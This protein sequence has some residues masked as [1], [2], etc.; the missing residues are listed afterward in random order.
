MRMASKADQSNDLGSATCIAKRL[1]SNSL[2]ECL[3]VVA[4][5][6]ANVLVSLIHQV[7]QSS[8][9]LQEEISTNPCILV[10]SIDGIR[11][12]ILACMVPSLSIFHCTTSILNGFLRK[13]ITS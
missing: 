13:F 8:G 9:T 12:E 4:K 7:L 1:G 6:G 11:G 2:T 10:T 3:S 5:I